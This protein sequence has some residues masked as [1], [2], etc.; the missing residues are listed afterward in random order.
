M[1]VG[2]AGVMEAVHM[3]P[4]RG[5][6][7]LHLPFCNPPSDYRVYWTPA[8]DFALEGPLPRHDLFQHHLVRPG[9]R[10]QRS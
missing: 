6:L 1:E 9:I 4:D 8:A 2:V 3:D 5:R 10:D 7:S